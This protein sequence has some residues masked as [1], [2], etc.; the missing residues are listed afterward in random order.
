MQ[1]LHSYPGCVAG[2]EKAWVFF[3]Y[4]ACAWVYFLYE[5]SD[6]TGDLPCV[7]VEYWCVS[8]CDCG[9]VVNYDDLTDEFFGYCWWIVSCS[10]DVSSVYVGFCNA[11]HVHSNVVAWFS[12]W[13]HGVV[14]F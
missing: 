6:S 11:S 3:G 4:L 7:V 12:K 9:W 5:L 10:C 2:F 14:H 1:W 13:D 8:C